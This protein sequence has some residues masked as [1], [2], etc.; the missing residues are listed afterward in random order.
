MLPDHYAALEI[1]PSASRE[2]IDAAF[3]VLMAANHPDK[4]GDD[5]RAKALSE[6]YATL[7]NQRS[8]KKYDRQRAAD[9]GGQIGDYRVLEKIADGGFG[10]TYRGEHVL[11][12]LPVCIKHASSV[13]PEDERILMEEAK[14]IWDLRHFAIPAV[15]TILRLDDGSLALVMSYVAGPTLADIVEKN[16]KISAEHVC[17]ITERILNGLKYLHYHGVVHG[18]VKPGNIIIQPDSH[19]VCLVDYGLSLIRPSKDSGSK[20]YTPYFGSPEQEKGFT[21][22]PESD[23][24]SLGMT[25]I[26]ALGGDVRRRQVPRDVPDPLCRFIKKLI[27]KD[28]LSRPRW[29]SEDLIEELRSIRRSVFGRGSS[30]GMKIPG[31]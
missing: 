20:G 27:A 2:V 28:T 1:A 10:T 26:Y 23:L 29:E 14:A 25:M 8:R 17:W 5:R 9:H 11:S 12:G 7:K 22:L 16:K 13:S 30:F 31:F 24:Y 15:R 21:I 3:K 18:D 19:M 6:A 4:T